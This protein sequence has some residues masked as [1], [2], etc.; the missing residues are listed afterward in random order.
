MTVFC[1]FV[2]YLLVTSCKKDDKINPVAAENQKIID[3]LMYFTDS[4]MRSTK[5]SGIYVVIVDRKKCL[6]RYD[7][8]LWTGHEVG[9]NYQY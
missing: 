3:Q 6:R 2:I 8:E 5:I 1:L 7:N 4:V 9:K